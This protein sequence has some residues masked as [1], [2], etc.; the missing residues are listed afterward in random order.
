MANS[1]C[2]FHLPDRYCKT[3]TSPART[4]A[5]TTPSSL[6][7]AISTSL[8]WPFSISTRGLSAPIDFSTDK[9]KHISMIPIAGKAVAA[10]KRHRKILSRGFMLFKL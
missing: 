6:F 2:P 7:A 5:M 8:N 3:N 4:L 10:G 1:P 9:E